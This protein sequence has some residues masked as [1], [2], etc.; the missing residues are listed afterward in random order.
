MYISDDN[1]PELPQKENKI[2]VD[3]HHRRDKAGFAIIVNIICESHFDLT[4][5]S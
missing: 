3:I 5:V 2:F 1:Q 4:T